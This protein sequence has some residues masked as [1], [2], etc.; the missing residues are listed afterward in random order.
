[1]DTIHQ[2][3]ERNSQTHLNALEKVKNE[4]FILERLF[5]YHFLFGYNVE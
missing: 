5:S 2:F 4:M 3:T 1:M